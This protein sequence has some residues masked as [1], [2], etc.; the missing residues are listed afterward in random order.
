[1]LLFRTDSAPENRLHSS[2]E[3][4]SFCVNFHQVTEAT[5]TVSL[6]WTFADLFTAVAHRLLAFLLQELLLQ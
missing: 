3:S 4:R 5:F 1:M 2:G 6:N